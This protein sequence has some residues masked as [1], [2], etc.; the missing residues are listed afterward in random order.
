[1]L[2]NPEAE[3]MNKNANYVLIAIIVIGIGLLFWFEPGRNSIQPERKNQNASPESLDYAAERENYSIYIPDK[4]EEKIDEYNRIEAIITVQDCIRENGF[5]KAEAK[6]VDINQERLLSL[7]E[8]YYHP[9]KG[10]ED[11]WVIQYSGKDNM[12]LYFFK[13]TEGGVT[14]ASLTS[15]F[16]NYVSMAYREELTEDYNRNLYPIDEQLEN[17]PLEDCDNMIS[18]FCK[19]IGFSGDIHIIHRTLD[20]KIMKDEAEELHQN[21]TKTK[22]DYRWSPDDNSYYC[23]ISQLCNQIPVIPSFYLTSYADILNAGG[24]KCLLN[25]ERIA[26]FYVYDIYEIQYEEEYEKLLKFSDIIEQYKKY[27]SIALQDYETVITDITMRVL[28]I[29]QGGGKYKMTPVW[30]FYGYWENTAGDVKGEHAVFIN[31]VTGARL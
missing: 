24:H 25:S 3:A 20:Y 26:S 7:L 9:Q 2:I 8:K 4:W 6:I 11:E 16:R 29:K 10:E 22:P 1:M 5:Q 30:I 19:S 12:Y 31:A 23:T 13:N 18:A 21:G 15:S 27:A 14:E 28:A 17:F